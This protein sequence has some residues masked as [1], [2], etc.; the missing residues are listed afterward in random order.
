LIRVGIIGAGYMGRMHAAIYQKIEDVKIIAIADT[1]MDMAQAIGDA[2]E[3]Q[4][5]SSVAEMLK[6]AEL[7]MV[8][9]CLPTPLHK[10]TTLFAVK[11]GIPVLCEKPIALNV[12]DAKEMIKAASEN[13]TLLMIAHCLRFAREYRLLKK[14]I[15]E[16]RYGKLISLHFHRNSCVPSWSAGNWLADRSKSGGVAMDLHIHDTDQVLYL[17]GRPQA[18]YARGSSSNISTFYEYPDVTVYAEASWRSQSKF[19]YSMGYDAAFEKASVVF[20]DKKVRITAQNDCPF[21]MDTVHW[22]REEALAGLTDDF[23]Q[24]EIH[25]FVNCLKN[26]VAPE[27]CLPMDSMDS[28]ETVTAE[29]R[30]V[31]QNEKIYL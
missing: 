4:I 30:S 24:N 23:Y 31:A 7:D 25:Y 1:H 27:I 10:E 29:I 26:A 14:I 6:K 21:E 16:Q 19:N 9:I 13:G 20:L 5:Y 15:M 11:K 17:L 28:L 22:E 2:F 12:F 18:V 3:A 8:D